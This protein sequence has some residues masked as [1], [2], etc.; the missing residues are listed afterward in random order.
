MYRD[1]AEVH[2][3]VAKH[4]GTRTSP[5]SGYDFPGMTDAANWRRTEIHKATRFY[6]C[7]LCGQRFTGPHATYT[8]LAKRHDR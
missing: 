3:R 4:G 5:K 8:H 1:R 7:Q 6:A 2:P